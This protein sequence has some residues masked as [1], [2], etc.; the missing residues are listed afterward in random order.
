[1]RFDM[2]R[3]WNDAVAMISGN[4]EVVLVVAGLFFFLPYVGLVLAM[5]D[6]A[7]MMPT[8]G[9]NDPEAAARFLTEFY[10]RIWWIVLVMV[11]LQAVGTLGLLYLLTDRRPTVAD[12]LKFGLKALLPFL[13]MQILQSLIILVA[14][15]PL[16]A[17]IGAG[18]IP[19]AILVGLAT[20]VALIYLLTKFSLATAV[21]AREQVLNP[22]AALARSWRLTRRNSL[23]MLLFYFLL[24][25]VAVIVSAVVSPLS[26][27]VFGLL[28]AQ[29]ALFGT[30]L[31]SG[32]MNGVWV[33]LFLAVQA[34]IHDQLS[35]TSSTESLNQT[36]G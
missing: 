31:V 12:A 24:G 18:S 6:V 23:M 7:T 16:L 2:S 4:R 28:G 25:L 22:I 33:V 36:F 29:V 1:M 10:G 15:L 35:G 19:A 3:A 34:A 9:S 20:L 13:G 11:V 30:A 26:S 27:L 17:A 14:L 5:P 32:L 21:M 8:A